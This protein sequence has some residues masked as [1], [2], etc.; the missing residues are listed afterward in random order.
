MISNEAVRQQLDNSQP[1]NQPT[2]QPVSTSTHYTTDNCPGLNLAS[3]VATTFGVGFSP[4]IS[5]PSL[6]VILLF[7]PLLDDHVVTLLSVPVAAVLLSLRNQRGI[8][9]ALWTD[10]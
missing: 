8:A 2:R 9:L 10:R 1:G 7:T 4:Q 6:Y 3:A 5:F